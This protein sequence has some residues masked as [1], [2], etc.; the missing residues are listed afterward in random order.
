MSFAKKPQKTETHITHDQIHHIRKK[1]VG[2]Y[3][4]SP[5][6]SDAKGLLALLLQGLRSITEIDTDLK[7]GFVSFKIIS[8]NNRDLCVCASSGCSTRGR[9]SEKL[10]NYM[11]NT[12][13]GEI[14]TK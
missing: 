5:G 4:F 6:D 2:S 9:F 3:L 7:G 14:K 8:L 13:E 11:E 12:K 1:L 10:Q